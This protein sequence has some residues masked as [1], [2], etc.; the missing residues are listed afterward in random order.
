M[1]ARALMPGHAY[2]CDLVGPP[3]ICW[4]GGARPWSIENGIDPT[5]WRPGR[6]V[7]FGVLEATGHPLALEVVRRAKAREDEQ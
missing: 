5:D 6:G 2:H 4:T 1:T 3:R 7:P